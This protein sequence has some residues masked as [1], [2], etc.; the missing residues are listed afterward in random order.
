MPVYLGMTREETKLEDYNKM[1]YIVSN[2]GGSC[3]A[4]L[5]PKEFD[6]PCPTCS[7]GLN[8]TPKFEI[9]DKFQGAKMLEEWT[10][11][12]I[13]RLNGYFLFSFFFRENHL[14]QIK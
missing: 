6:V 1:I 7:R 11:R 8:V 5:L 13:N 12:F 2:W 9:H 14:K 3:F 4:K 10:S